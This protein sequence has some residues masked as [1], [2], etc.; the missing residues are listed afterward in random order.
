ML[1]TAAAALAM[2]LYGGRDRDGGRHLAS[3]EMTVK[4]LRLC[5]ILSFL[6]SVCC[7]GCGTGRPPVKTLDQWQAEI[8][9]VRSRGD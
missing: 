6:L 2:A 8:E 4:A 1:P 5:L 7:V 3:M 9:R